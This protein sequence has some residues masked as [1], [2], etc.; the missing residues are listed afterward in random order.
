MEELKEKVKDKVEVSTKMQQE[1]QR[2][3]VGRI[4]P[5]RGHTVFE[6]N[7]E[8][9]TIVPAEYDE[10]VLKLDLNT[11]KAPQKKRSLTKKEHCLYIPALN[12]KN[13]VKILKRNFGIIFK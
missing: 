11:F 2:V 8:K 6:V 12:K 5:Q 13:V 9:G 7:L 4:M 10:Q 3:L 1:T